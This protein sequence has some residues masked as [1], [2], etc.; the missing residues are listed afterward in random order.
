MSDVSKAIFLSYAS[1]DA[2]AAKRI[3]DALR[4][5]G[6]EVW[7]DQSELVGGDQWDGKIRGQIS[8][9]ALFMPVISANTQARLEGYFRIEWKIAAR[10]THAMAAAKAFLL[11]VV[12][13]DT[14]DASAHVPD[15]F[16][17]VQ[18]T[19]LPGGETP[20]AFCARVRKIL[21]GNVG[22]SLL[23]RHGP[24][25][26]DNDARGRAQGAPL[27]EPGGTS[28]R[29]PS[30]WWWVLPIFG[31]TMALVLVMK[32]SHPAALPKAASA[33]AVVV[34][35]PVVSPVAAELA[36]IRARIVPDRWQRGDFDAIAPALD[37]L[38]QAEPENADA[39]ALSSII[40]SLQVLRILDPGTRPLEA[41][42]VAAERSLRLAPESALGLLA[43]GMHLVANIS[44]GGDPLACREPID[45]A[46]AALSPDALTRYTGLV[47]VWLGYDF[48]ATERRTREWLEAEPKASY[49][50]W[51]LAS[52]NVA[53]RHPEQT[54][55]WAEQAI[56]D[57]DITGVRALN[58]LSDAHFY[59]RADLKAMRATLERVPVRM[60]SNAR[61]VYNRWLLAMAEQRWDEALQELAQVPDP[62]LFD[63]GYNGPKALL[64]GL[65]HQRAGRTEAAATQFREAERLVRERLVADTDNEALR[66]VLALTLAS[67]GRATEARSELALVEPLVRGRAPNVYRTRLVLLFA[68]TYGELG[69]YPA[70]VFWLRKLLAEPS[71]VPLTPAS[72]R[73]DP[74][75]NRATDAPEVQ[76]LLKE[77]A[78]LDP[79]VGLKTE[80]SGQNSDISAPL[81][82]KSVAVLAFANLSDDKANEYFSDGISEEL[83]NVLAK[84]PGLKVAARTSAFYFKGKEVPV[85]E[86]AK[87]LGV[88]Y[89][90]EG[91]V[92]KQG[93][94]VRITAQLIKAADGFHVWSDTFTRDLKDIFAVQDEIAGLI[95]K[96]L[97]LKMGIGEAGAR[98]AVSP[99]A[100]QEYLL[101][102][103]AAAKAGSADMREAVTHFDRAVALEPKYT[104]AWVQLASAHTRLGRWGGASTLKS[105]AAARVAIDRA[106]ALEP[107]SPEVLLALGWILRTGEWNWREAE[108]A[109]RRAL[110]L[111]PNQPEILAGA[112]V[113]LFNIGQTDEAFR[114]ARRAV[115]LDP[116]NAG[117]QIDLSIMFG[118]S[119]NWSEAERAA[120]RALQLA[121]GGTSYHCLLGWSLIAQQR[122]DEAE[123]EI[124]LDKSEDGVD[125]FNA[126]GLLAIA[127]GQEK[128]A[129][130]WLARLEEMARTNADQA[131]LQQ[132]IAWL[133]TILG[134]KDRAF[135]ALEKAYTSRDPSM[136]WLLNSWW[137]Q[138]LTSD[139]RWPALVRKVGLA[140]E[141]LK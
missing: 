53:R 115:Q 82:Q 63:L 66:A 89:V 21:D 112:A 102:R 47:S 18:W 40:N 88:A 34:P 19:K 57:S 68:Q 55:K 25:T 39:L 121:P 45:K 118:L 137:L 27:H 41:G 126:L 6:I 140:D 14:H 71:G 117:T 31:V 83:L 91:S 4:Q 29:G 120:R 85:P 69:D 80:H 43:L 132:N 64:A 32:Q 13:D 104:A 87:Q 123:A 119:K 108:R 22:A 17:E 100:Y 110:A 81:D 56:M 28:P 54:I 90:V 113:L 24:A 138:P 105:W 94:K 131:D 49:P 20:P 16:R 96:T 128:V 65:A 75:F 35:S 73:L 74:R 70:M 23:S 111:Q 122:Y 5:A 92:R 30:K 109:F 38:I 135:A 98:Q 11:P 50:A 84:I 2:E 8:S 77:F 36:R 129:R 72:F 10:R 59:L 79:A 37:R 61:V 134:E 136:S 127:R 101:G 125:R 95:A 52:E 139:P 99:E 133:N 48:E 26:A 67:A 33:P 7:F 141:Q 15:E 58:T 116:L 114:L 103:A 12:I 1:Q 51:I 60:R 130:E 76:A 124:N 46:L 3:C 78:S 93:E 86:I 42:K 97:E 107:D 44:R 9:C 62:M 106:R